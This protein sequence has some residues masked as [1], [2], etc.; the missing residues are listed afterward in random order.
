MDE[1]L[2]HSRLTTPIRTGTAPAVGTQAQPN[3]QTRADA[4]LSFREILEGLSS[5]DSGLTFSK[6]AAARLEQRE[7]ALSESGLARLDEGVRIAREKGLTNTLIL[8]DDSAFVVNA[9][10]GKVITSLSGL[11]GRAIT[12]IDGTV[13]V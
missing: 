11:R 3:A 10:A 9:G 13:I 6:H 1:L 4:G 7:I 8:V 2:L 12:N 5:T